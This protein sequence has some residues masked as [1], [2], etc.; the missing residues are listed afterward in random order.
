VY[1]WN[2]VSTLGSPRVHMPENDQ[3]QRMALPQQPQSVRFGVCSE[4]RR[5]LIPCH[6]RPFNQSFT[7]ITTV[8]TY[9]IRAPTS[10]PSKRLT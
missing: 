10:I 1:V 6:S 9:S 4:H 8:H 2:R 5:A 3:D 7:S